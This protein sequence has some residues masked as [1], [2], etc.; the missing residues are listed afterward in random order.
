VLVQPYLR[1]GDLVAPFGIVHE[2]AEGY[3]LVCHPDSVDDP[4][5][6]ALAEWLK[7]LAAE[8]VLP[9]ASAIRALSRTAVA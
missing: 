7:L 6:R 1:S 4:R 9:M 5:I 3:H 8:P 2:T